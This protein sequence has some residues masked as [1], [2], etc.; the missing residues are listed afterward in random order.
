VLLVNALVLIVEGATLDIIWFI[1]NQTSF[2]AP[3]VVVS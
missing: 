2:S 3:K 1:A